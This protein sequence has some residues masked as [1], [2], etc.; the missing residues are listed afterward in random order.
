MSGE[1]GMTKSDDAM[2]MS[3]MAKSLGAAG[4]WGAAGPSNPWASSLAAMATANTLAFGFASQFWSLWLGMA[5]APLGRRE[6]VETVE[7]SAH[8]SLEFL[9]YGV[10][11][12]G[13]LAGD[14]TA[15]PA[16]A[17]RARAKA[18]PKT[19]ATEMSAAAAQPVAAA[20]LQPEDF[21]RPKKTDKPA[22]PDDL[23][24]ISGV[25]PKLEKVLNGLGV[26]TYAQIAAWGREEIAW[27]DD[28]LA[29]NGRIERDRWIAQA[30]ALAAGGRDE[31]VKV[32]GREPR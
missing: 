4:V 17:K 15:K 22:A 28:Y 3:T 1:G 30:G 8:D 13:A 25:G 11:P 7:H 5:M 16:R 18:D 19:A 24:L 31:Y 2:D 32:F 23:K 29:F 6:A 12:E 26:W 20:T 21:R 10:E 9:S 14:E 27:V